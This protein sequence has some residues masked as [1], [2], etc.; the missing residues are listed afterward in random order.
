M[1]LK[2]LSCTYSS[3]LDGQARTIRYRN[4]TSNYNEISIAKLYTMG[5]KGAMTWL[6]KVEEQRASHS[7][8]LMPTPTC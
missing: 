7:N 3:S 4:H 5:S 6:D 2:E 1:I 8:V